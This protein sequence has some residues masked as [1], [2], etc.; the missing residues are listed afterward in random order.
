MKIGLLLESHDKGSEISGVSLV[1]KRP[2]KGAVF[3]CVGKADAVV[4]P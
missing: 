2:R 1:T 3:S 4:V